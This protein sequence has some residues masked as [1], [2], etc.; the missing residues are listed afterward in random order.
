MI[1]IKKQERGIKLTKL[2]RAD[3]E[4]VYGLLG[5]LGKISPCEEYVPCCPNCRLYILKGELEEYKAIIEY[6]Y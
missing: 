6:G 2:E 5:S 4:R 3:I 1:A